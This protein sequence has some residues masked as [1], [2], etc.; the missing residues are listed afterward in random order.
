MPCLSSWRIFSFL[1]PSIAT[2]TAIERANDV[3]RIHKRQAHAAAAQAHLAASSPPSILSPSQELVSLTHFLLSAQYGSLPMPSASSSDSN[4]RAAIATAIAPSSPSTSDSN[5]ITG[6]TYD[7][8]TEPLHAEWLLD[9]DYSDTEE[10]RERMRQF[11]QEVWKGEGKLVV[12]GGSDVWSKEVVNVLR[13]DHRVMELAVV[14]FDARGKRLVL[15]LFLCFSSFV[16]VLLMA[17]LSDLSALLLLNCWIPLGL[18][19]TITE[20]KTNSTFDCCLFTLVDSQ[21]VRPALTRL[22]PGHTFPLVVLGGTPIGSYAEIKALQADNKLG[23][24]LAAH[25][26][27]VEPRPQRTRRSNKPVVRRR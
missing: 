9:F 19:N 6:T 22:L 7:P 26:V 18:A 13:K 2:A 11:E 14:D 24:M 3:Y 21:I 20:I 25:D 5:I 16:S 12:F 1:P 17:F 10:S 23:T 8:S 27:L 4:G 15:P